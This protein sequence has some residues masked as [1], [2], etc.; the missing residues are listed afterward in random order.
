MKPNNLGGQIRK[1]WAE[2]PRTEAFPSPR[3]KAKWLIFVNI[4]VITLQQQTD[5][6]HLPVILAQQYPP[7][8]NVHVFLLSCFSWSY[9]G[10]C[11]TSATWRW[12]FKKQKCQCT[13]I[14]IWVY[15][16]S[17]SNTPCWLSLVIMGLMRDCSM[18]SPWK[19]CPPRN[20]GEHHR[21]SL[22]YL[23]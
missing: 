19:K 14:V 23:Y 15:P 20:I 2:K 9:P 18:P 21:S 16:E 4:H 8:P 17:I 7:D 22:A 3:S 1:E 13:Q 6:F 10:P 12:N 5:I 11:V